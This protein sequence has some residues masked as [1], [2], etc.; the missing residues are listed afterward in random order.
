MIGITLLLIFMF[1][2]VIMSYKI[3][4]LAKDVE[5]VPLFLCIFAISMSMF[6]AAFGN[7]FYDQIRLQI[8]FFVF[9]GIIIQYSNLLVSRK[10][11]K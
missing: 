7:I 8:I 10:D 4:I 1:Y 2:N 6:V 5:V 3:S 9:S 11:I